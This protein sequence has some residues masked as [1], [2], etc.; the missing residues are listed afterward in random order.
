MEAI[1]IDVHFASYPAAVSAAGGLPVQ[2][3]RDADVG[4]LVAR[5]DG[6][7]LSGGAD[8]DPS[9]YGA[10]PEADLGETELE[11]DAWELALVRAALAAGLPTLG[12]CRGAQLLNVALGGTLVQHVG[13]NEGDGHPRFDDDPALLCHTVSIAE[14]SL[15][16]EVLGRMIPVNSLHHQTLDQIGEGL[17][18]TGRAS[19]GV[20]EV[21]E[22]PG[23]SVLAVQWHPEMLEAPDPSISWL[24]ATAAARSSG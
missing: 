20:A 4:E 23:H 11:R 24:V 18:V 12:I 6:L 5:L 16:A 7:I 1:E 2:L 19:D 8:I 17:V 9:W 21:I 14:G 22:L 10:E 13:L 3:T 15:A